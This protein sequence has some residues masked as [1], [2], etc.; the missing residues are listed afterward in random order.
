MDSAHPYLGGQKP[1]HHGGIRNKPLKW[2]TVL[3][4]KD[5][6][7]HLYGR[8]SVNKVITVATVVY[9]LHRGRPTYSPFSMCPQQSNI[10]M[11]VNGTCDY[12]LK[13]YYSY[14]LLP[15]PFSYQFNSYLPTMFF[16]K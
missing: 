4:Y 8:C 16:Q 9:F 3:P 15:H 5:R 1:G 2:S 12:F 6:A 13:W 10:I 7:L 11:L 14:I